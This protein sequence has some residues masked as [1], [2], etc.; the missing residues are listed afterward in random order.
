MRF[1][2]AE[3]LCAKLISLGLSSEI[4]WRCCIGL[5]SVTFMA[6]FNSTVS[7]LQLLAAAFGARLGIWDALKLLKGYGSDGYGAKE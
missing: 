1:P 7:V 3:L 2:L 4:T 5:V 6:F